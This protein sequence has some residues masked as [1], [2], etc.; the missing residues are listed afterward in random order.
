MLRISTVQQPAHGVEYLALFREALAAAPISDIKAA[1]AYATL[2]G[3]AVLDSACTNALGSSWNEMRKQ[4]LLSFDYCRTEP[5]AIQML[6]H[7]QNSEVRIHDGHAVVKRH[8]CI[9]RLPF[10][11]KLFLLRGPGTLG[12]IS[13]SG[14]LSRN[15]LTKGHEAGTLILTSQPEN[16]IEAQLARLCEDQ[17]TWFEERWRA[18]ALVDEVL[19]DYEAM[20]ASAANLRSPPPTE[21]DCTADES[22]AGGPS[23]RVLGSTD[24]ARLRACNALWIE[25]GNITKNRGPG[26]PGNQLMLARM[27]RV[28]FGFPAED[29]QPD[30]DVGVVSISFNGQV[31]RD[32]SLTFSNNSMDKLTLPIPGAGGP[33]AYDQQNLLFVKTGPSSCR[34]TIG[35]DA[36]KQRWIAKSK[37]VDGYRVMTSGRQW[38]VFSV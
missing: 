3:V 33:G 36:D 30:T 4:W 35:D 24:L 23:L 15:G 13:G 1:V 21:D 25:A 6:Q 34:L 2:G 28:F 5:I 29:L 11:P 10:H 26:N 8:L 17:Q 31:R 22:I 20:H 38:G 18:A 27:T 37:A 16:A 7:L 32:C 9:P 19:R 12:A 14:N